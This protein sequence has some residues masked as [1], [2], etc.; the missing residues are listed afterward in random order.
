MNRKSITIIVSIVLLVGLAAWLAVSKYPIQVPIV[1]PITHEDAGGPESSV[2]SAFI[3]QNVHEDATRVFAETDESPLPIS[4]EWPFVEELGGASV[5]FTSVF[6]NWRDDELPLVLPSEFE[7][8]RGW[9]TSKFDGYLQLEGRNGIYC[10]LPT[11][12][13]TERGWATYSLLETMVSVHVDSVSGFEALKALMKEAGAKHEWT[14]RFTIFLHYNDWIYKPPDE[15][16]EPGTTTI[17]MDNVTAR[18]VLHAIMVQCDLDMQYFYRTG[19]M[20][21][22]FYQN[23]EKLLLDPRERGGPPIP[24]PTGDERWAWAKE[25]KELNQY[26]GVQPLVPQEEGQPQEETDPE[27]E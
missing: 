14:R 9:A 19:G 26:V 24:M 15:F 4:F 3:Q 2:S 23:G 18:A 20:S 12:K 10:L 1:E 21:I 27:R 5:K 25:R 13:G 16:L 22:Y 6:P 11:E 17:H 7:A 8:K